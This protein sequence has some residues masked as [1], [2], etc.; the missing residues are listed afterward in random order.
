MNKNIK[1]MVEQNFL[2]LNIKV[3]IKREEA[4]KNPKRTFRQLLH[5]LEDTAREAIYDPD[6]SKQKTTIYLGTR[7]SREIK[8]LLKINR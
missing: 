1:A 5:E 8:D 3:F 7:S 2:E 6:R 4:A